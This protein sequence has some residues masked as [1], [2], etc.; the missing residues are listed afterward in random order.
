[1]NKIISLIFITST[2]LISE[3]IKDKNKLFTSICTEDV[4]LGIF[5]RDGNY[6]PSGLKPKQH[7]VQKIR[8]GNVLESGACSYSNSYLEYNREHGNRIF[9]MG[10]YNIREVD[11]EFYGNE[12]KICNESWI[13]KDGQEILEGI[14][15]E[16]FTL[17][18]NKYFQQSK[19][20]G[21]MNIGIVQD[22]EEIYKESIPSLSVGKCKVITQ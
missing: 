7:I 15:C 22:I 11:S 2:L 4:K 10:C 3:E 19:I 1:M 6:S 12:S 8:K 9:R 18:P 13:K 16:N 14:D 17:I 21:I 5:F 20:N